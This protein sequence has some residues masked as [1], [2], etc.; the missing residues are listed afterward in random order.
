MLTSTPRVQYFCVEPPECDVLRGMYLHTVRVSLF[1]AVDR[2]CRQTNERQ[3][4]WF[5]FNLLWCWNRE[6]F[7]VDFQ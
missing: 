5:I 7:P 4:V 2:G 1:Q 6:C 3:P